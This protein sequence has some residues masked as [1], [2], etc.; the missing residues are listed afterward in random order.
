[1][2]YAIDRTD[3]TDVLIIADD[4][5][6]ATIHYNEEGMTSTYYQDRAGKFT[7]DDEMWASLSEGKAYLKHWAETEL[8]ERMIQDALNWL[9]PTEDS[10]VEVELYELANEFNNRKI[11]ANVDTNQ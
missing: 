3:L 1:M 4:G 8:D 11:H 5:S 7:F 10:W 6:V 9:C 2:K